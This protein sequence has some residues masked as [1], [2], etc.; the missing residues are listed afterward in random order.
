[1]YVKD[2]NMKVYRWVY[3]VN[4]LLALAPEAYIT[5]SPGRQEDADTAPAVNLNLS[6]IFQKT[7][8]YFSINSILYFFFLTSEEKLHQ[9]EHKCCKKQRTFGK[10]TNWLTESGKICS[11]FWSPDLHVIGVTAKSPRLQNHILSVSLRPK[12]MMQPSIVAKYVTP[13]CHFHFTL[14]LPKTW[15]CVAACSCITTRRK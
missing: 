6:P 12:V 9:P 8:F 7:F 4:P 1:M 3:K 13:V 15:S 14:C 2:G 5:L 10:N 11:I